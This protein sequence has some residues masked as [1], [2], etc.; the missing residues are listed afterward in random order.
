[1][2]KAD[3]SIAEILTENLYGLG[4]ND[5]DRCEELVARVKDDEDHMLKLLGRLYVEEKRGG[6]KAEQGLRALMKSSEVGGALETF[7]S[8]K[9]DELA[10]PTFPV[11]SPQDEPKIKE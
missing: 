3:L 2:A 11:V 8:L 4:L 9:S 5:R 7:S 6:S 10:D 1:M